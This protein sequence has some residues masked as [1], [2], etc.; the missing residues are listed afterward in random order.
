M[1][2]DLR[3]NG[4]HSLVE[5]LKTFKKFHDD[6]DDPNVAFTLKDAILRSHH[7][8]EALFKNALL[9]YNSVL[10]LERDY[11]I[12]EFVENYQKFL[13]GDLETELDEVRTINLKE[14]IERLNKFELLK[15][16]ERDYFL[17]SE[18]IA[19]LDRYRNRLQHFSL[20]LILM[21]LLECSELFFLELLRYWTLFHLII[22]YLVVFE[23]RSQY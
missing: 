22:Q 9:Q 1:N 6:P 3:T 13:R 4:I 5:A 19:K 17:F 8:L 16:D 15:I 12:G 23:L 18:A 20:S 10:L 21:L 2:L 7:A 11:K 14:T